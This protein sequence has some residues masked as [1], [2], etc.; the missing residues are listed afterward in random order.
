M[1]SHRLV[2][3]ALTAS[4]VAVGLT[5]S[6]LALA[7]P[8]RGDKVD[9]KALMQSGLRLLEAKDYLG[10]L[11]VFKD[12]YARFPSA[13]ILLNIGTTLGLLDRKVDAA[14]AYQRYLD[15]P[16]TDPAKRA[17]VTAAL[18][19]FD[20]VIGK[21]EIT[22]TPRDA[23]LQIND[24]EWVPAA[25]AH[26][27]RIPA[28]PYKVRARKDKFQGEAKSARIE[29][30]EQATLVF[31]LAALPEEASVGA[32]TGT[33]GAELDVGT[34]VG[35]VAHAEP[36]PRGRLGAIAEAHV[37]VVHGGVAALVGVIADVAGPLQV[38]VT[39][40]LGPTYGGYAGAS[41]AFG[42]GTL[43]PFLAAGVPVFASAGARF[44]VRAAGGVEV[45]LTP[46][47]SILVEAGAEM[48]LNPE[49]DIL[50]AAFIPALGLTG[51]L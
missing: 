35:V 40:I 19:G 41:F 7:Q 8:N 28:G 34:G 4:L 14:N 29:L 1:I 36:A 39:A 5:T 26:L 12:A 51:R 32:H 6:G 17:D 25:A 22:V 10:A 16:D 11:A 42:A 15:A 20:K 44:G 48:M 49:D 23:E 27:V 43:R 24:G 45:V 37:D 18:V 47:V 31:T 2:H 3:R 9:A 21:L 50:R 33:T 38:Q 46:H 13:K 30:G